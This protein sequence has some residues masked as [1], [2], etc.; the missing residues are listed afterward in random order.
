MET[1]IFL[2]AH[3]DDEIAIFNHIKNSLQSNNKTL[4]IYATNG[5]I[6]K[7]ENSE[8]IEKRELESSYVLRK[9]GVKKKNI[10][11]LGKKLNINSYELHLNLDIVYKKLNSLIKKIQGK[12]II[13]T[14]S[15]EGGNMDHDSCY[16]ITLKLMSKF[17]RVI[18]AFQF[19]MYN[20][21]KMLLKFYKAFS[22]IK[23]NG[24]LVKLDINF[25]EK[26]KFIC[27][28]FSYKSQLKIWIGLYPFLILNI[29]SNNYGYLQ[30]IKRKKLLKKPH[31]NELWYEKRK[32]GS[33]NKNKLLFLKFLT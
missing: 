13:Y 12:I 32:F 7:K 31:G 9:I 1:K 2:L 14:N 26:I 5:R 20:S 17:P 3:Q 25:K 24:P 27:L 30:Q 16:I 33:Y 18:K 8:I 11:F 10:I 28:L 22:P 6:K 4:I 21:N 29:L 15:W 23:N 19:A